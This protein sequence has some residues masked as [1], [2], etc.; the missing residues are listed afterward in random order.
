[1]LSF[2]TAQQTEANVWSE[3]DAGSPCVCV[4]LFRLH[5]RSQSRWFDP[6]SD[7][8]QSRRSLLWGH[9]CLRNFLVKWGKIKEQKQPS[10]SISYRFILIMI[11][12]LM[13]VLVCVYV[14]VSILRFNLSDFH[15]SYFSPFVFPIKNINTNMVI[16]I[17]LIRKIN[18]SENQWRQI[19][20]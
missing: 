9:E 13:H 7:R 3:G 4:P 8:G 12:L 18:K 14:N 16:C 1:M 2:C 17:A 5:E 11:H 20:K 6:R 10:H 15:I 19:R